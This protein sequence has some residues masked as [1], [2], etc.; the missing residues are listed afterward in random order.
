MMTSNA[1]TTALVYVQ[2]ARKVGLKPENI[3]EIVPRETLPPKP[4]WRFLGIED[5]VH[6]RRLRRFY[7]ENGLQDVECQYFFGTNTYV[8][9]ESPQ[10]LWFFEASPTV[11]DMPR[12]NYGI[13]EHGDIHFVTVYLNGVVAKRPN[14]VAPPES[15]EWLLSSEAS[16]RRLE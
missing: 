5:A 4:S 10:P 14:N 15:V 2:E 6:R 11:G 13:D 3:Y 1:R 7:R 12:K 9:R 16:V 8:M